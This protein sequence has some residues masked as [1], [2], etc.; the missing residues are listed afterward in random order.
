MKVSC[1]F[2]PQIHIPVPTCISIVIH[3]ST[4]PSHS[5][6]IPSDATSLIPSSSTQLGTTMCYF[7]ER[8]YHQDP[9]I[10]PHNRNTK[11]HTTLNEHYRRNHSR[12]LSLDTIVYPQKPPFSFPTCLKRTFS[13]ST[14][15]CFLWFLRIRNS[16]GVDRFFLVIS[17]IL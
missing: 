13:S 16:T 4:K 17:Y 11:S 1:P 5:F 12:L 15:T 3:K 9:S 2:S 14:A 8:C 7:L 6:Q 10:N